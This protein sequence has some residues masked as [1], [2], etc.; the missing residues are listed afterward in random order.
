MADGLY[1][2]SWRRAL[3]NLAAL[4]AALALTAGLLAARGCARRGDGGLTMTFW[5]ESRPGKGHPLM[6]AIRP[7]VDLDA[8]EGPRWPAAARS[9]RYD[10]W[11]YIPHRGHFVLALSVRGQAQLTLDEG[12]TRVIR[13]RSGPITTEHGHRVHPRRIHKEQRL[14]SRGWHRLRLEAQ[15]PRG[16]GSIR[17]FWLPPGRRGVVEYVEPAMVRP[18]GPRP[19][20]PGHVG[21]APR[22]R[23][24]AL[25]LLAILALLVAFWA[26]RPLHTW[27]GALRTDPETRLDAATVLG[28]FAVALA[29]RLWGLGGAGQ[30]WDEDVY[31]SAGRNQWLNL[32][33]ADFRAG[34]WQWNLEHPPVTRYLAG[35]GSLFG[36]HLNTARAMSAVAGALVVPVIYLAGRDLFGDRRVGGVA[37]AVAVGLPTLLAHSQVAGHESSSLLLYTLTC[38]LMVRGLLAEGRAPGILGAAAQ[39]GGL[40]VSCRLENL[41]AWFFVAALALWIALPR[42]RRSQPL[43]VALLLMPLVAGAVFL[44]VWPRLWSSPARH[45]GELLTYWHPDVVQKEY[46]W[47]QQIRTSWGYFPLYALVTTP[48]AVLGGLALFGARLGWRRG[49]AEGVIALWILA[50]LA[51]TPLV[52][53]HRDGIRYV[54]PIVVPIL[55]AA[56]AGTVWLADSLTNRWRAW[57]NWR[58]GPTLVAILAGLALAGPTA[59]AAHRIHPYYLDFYNAPSGGAHAAL[60]QR[61]YE[62]SWWGE[63]LAGSVRYLQR[64]ARPPAVVGMD[65]PARHTVVLHPDVRTTRPGTRPAP[66]FLLYAGEGLRGLWDQKNRRWRHPPGYRVVY[67]ERA[68]GVPLSRVYRKQ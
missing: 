66:D 26:R 49:R 53:F 46:F 30:T 42:L 19:K 59:W 6:K 61:R 25:G 54:L 13:A 14:L 40:L 15:L 68:E 57:R 17:L 56:A 58:P 34:S 55:L 50:P 22:D 64:H 62:W 41:T 7:T 27:L 60:E 38:Y 67:E 8:Q 65:V 35:L 52:P 31:F 1:T 12:R 33:A 21:P 44:A 29:A 48:T 36:E 45:L 5:A 39:C 9:V 28:L 18:D 23:W 11:I 2:V 63:G 10:G 51:A 37:A 4:A 43:P 3:T 20:V 16:T 32:L 47:G 24:I